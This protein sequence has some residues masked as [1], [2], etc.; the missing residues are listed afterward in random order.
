MDN[1]IRLACLVGFYHLHG[2]NIWRQDDGYLIEQ[3][4]EAGN[5][6]YDS[7][8]LVPVERG[9]SLATLQKFCNQTGEEMAEELGLP[10][11][12]CSLEDDPFEGEV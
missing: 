8:S 5:S 4:Y 7:A 10:W 12:G 1:E 11:A 2:Y 9:E 6:P 3:V